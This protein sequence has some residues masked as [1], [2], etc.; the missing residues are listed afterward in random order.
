MNTLVTER[1][2]Q[3]LVESDLASA[4]PGPGTTPDPAARFRLVS[5]LHRHYVAHLAGPE[6]FGT[7]PDLNADAEASTI[8]DAWLRWED[9]QVDRGRLPSSAATFADWFTQVGTAHT[10]PD[11]CAYLAHEATLQELAMFFLAE[12]LV[13]S[14][15]DDLVALAQI[16]CGDDAKLT[17]AENYWD[18][19]GEGEKARMHSR[20]FE[21][22][23]VHM[24]A[25]L[26]ERRIHPHHVL[27]TEVLE[28]ASLVLMYGINRR[29]TP[30]SLG[31]LGLMEFSA[32]D[33][34]KAMVDGCT[35]LGVPEDVITYQR[36]HIHVDDKHG[37]EWLH[38]VL[39]PL[40]ARSEELLREV[41]L[42]V[43]TRERV[44]NAYYA[45]VWAQ[46]RAAR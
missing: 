10:Q 9:A 30:R 21:H 19:M 7:I 39:T 38:Q 44:A 25:V 22:S 46:M 11:F 4:Y 5:R 31:A 35:R 23:A 37:S 41:A 24:R 17:L 8:A 13:D 3:A 34:F 2:L 15:F 26:A 40:V 32:P 6:D 28:N 14:R 45:R 36:I 29:L 18:E 27:S 16:G 33:R 1:P 20:L 12:E 43:L 42:G